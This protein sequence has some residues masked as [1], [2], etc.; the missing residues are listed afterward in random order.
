MLDKLWKPAAMIG[1]GV[2][3]AGPAFAHEDSFSFGG[4]G[5]ASD[6]T[7]TIVI[8][9]TDTAFDHKSIKIKSGETIRFKVVNKGELLHEFALGTPEMNK[10]HEGEMTDM[11]DSGMMTATNV[12]YTMM[13]AKGVEHDDPN[14]VVVE[15]GKSAD[16]IWH[17]E[18]KDNIEFACNVPG[19]Y[20]AG[21]HGAFT[22][23]K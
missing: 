7:R 6:V 19:H 5:K 20:E 3:L 17:F 9:M 13:Q 21:M 2:A 1:L 16:L 22:Y 4:P 14:A 12:N 18:G 23:S 8:D 10:D 11:M 15:P